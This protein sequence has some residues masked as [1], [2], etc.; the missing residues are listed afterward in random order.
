[1]FIRGKIRCKTSNVVQMDKERTRSSVD[2]GEEGSSLNSGHG[3]SSTGGADS[4]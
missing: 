4:D 1:M 2:K 3:A